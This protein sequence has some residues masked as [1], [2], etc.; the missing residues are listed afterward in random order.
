MKE[1]KFGKWTHVNERLPGRD[2]KVLA[3]DLVSGEQVLVTGAELAT[4]VAL[5]VW[6]PLMSKEAVKSWGAAFGDTLNG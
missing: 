6:M 2:E 1:P 5:Q 3:A 4:N